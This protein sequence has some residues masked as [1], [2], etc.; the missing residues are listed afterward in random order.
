M[1]SPY[2]RQVQKI[3]WLLERGNPPLKDVKVGSTELFQGQEK[4][5]III[6]TVRSN[7]EWVGFDLHHNLG[8]L[9]NPKRFN[10]AVTRA[11]ALLV[12]VGN[13][14]VLSSDPCWGKHLQRCRDL[15]AYKGVP[16]ATPNGSDAA[17][18]LAESLDRLM[19]DEE[20]DDDDDNDGEQT[21][22]TAGQAVQQEGLEMPTFE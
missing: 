1:I 11:K 19:L 18:V 22:Q 15:F 20:P 2:N 10:V 5:A 3:R 9:R 8:F 21:G 17:N 7:K 6:S 13:P 12:V 14:D 16:L 4:S